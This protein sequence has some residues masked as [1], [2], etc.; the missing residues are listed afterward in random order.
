LKKQAVPVPALPKPQ[1][2][3]TYMGDEAKSEAIKLASALRRAGIGAIEATGDKSLK[4]QLRQANNL[5]VKKA[6]IIGEQELATG[7]VVLRDMTSGEQ[8]NVPLRQVLDLLR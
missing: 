7:T 2:F 8:K 6:V 3:I 4:A 5:G 1:V